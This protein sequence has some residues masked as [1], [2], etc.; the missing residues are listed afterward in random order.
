MLEEVDNILV[1]GG[2]VENNKGRTDTVEIFDIA[3]GN[4]STGPSLPHKEFKVYMDFSGEMVVLGSNASQIYKYD[5]PNDQWTMRN[6]SLIH[7]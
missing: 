5:Q 6:L 7:I 3:S 2:S 1:A 4:W